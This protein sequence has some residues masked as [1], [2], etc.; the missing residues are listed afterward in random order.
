MTRDEIET[1]N[2]IAIA[3]SGGMTQI[4]NTHQFPVGKSTP[5]VRVETIRF[6]T[7]E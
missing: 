2:A 4:T 1:M 7:A 5:L 3:I 6:T